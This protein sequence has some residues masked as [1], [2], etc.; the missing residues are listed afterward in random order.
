MAFRGWDYPYWD[1]NELKNV[2]EW[3]EC[4]IDWNEI[5]ELSRFYRS[6]QFLHL[7]AVH[8]DHMPPDRFLPQQ[9]PP[10][11]NRSGYLGMIGATYTLTEIFEFASRL[12]L[13]GILEPVAEISVRLYNMNDHQLFTHSVSRFLRDIYVRTSDEPIV[14]E[15]SVTTTELVKRK[16]E[17]AL[18][19]TLE[20]LERFQLVGPS[21]E[22]LAEDQRKLR[23]RRLER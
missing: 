7:F 23:E 5:K 2:G 3:V 16:D 1:E 12:A 19:A 6:G 10:R 8:E 17:L 15:T 21:R 4:S 20:I 11:P 22:I 9:Y 14:V 18:D 13:K